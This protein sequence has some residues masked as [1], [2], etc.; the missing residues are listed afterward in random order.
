MGFAVNGI[1]T[2]VLAF[3]DDLIVAAETRA[4][5]EFLVKNAVAGLEDCDL[6]RNLE[7]CWVLSLRVDG[8]RRKW[9]CATQ[10]PFRINGQSIALVS[11][12]ESY[13]YLGVLVVV[14]GRRTSYGSI[15][16]D[17]LNNIRRAPLKPQQRL[18]ILVSHLV[19]KIMHRLVF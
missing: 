15:P 2:L 12:S 10:D 5:L 14:E 13:K 7:K 9:Y 8:R 1:S 6:Q 11:P 4:G 18:Y 3:A 16:E 19:P 17:G